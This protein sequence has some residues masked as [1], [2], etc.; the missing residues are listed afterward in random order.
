[1]GAACTPEYLIELSEV[2]IGYEGRMVHKALNLQL[3]AGQIVGLIGPSGCGKTTLMRTLL[4]LNRPVG[5]A[6]KIL[7]VDIHHVDVKTVRAVQDQWGVMFQNSAL[8]SA[9]TVAENILFPLKERY[10]LSTALQDQI[11]D[12]KMQMVGLD[13]TVKSYY[14]SAL[15]G[16]MKK[17]V[18]LARAL[19]MDPKI[20]FLDEPTA[21]LDPKSADAFDDLLL[22][23]HQALGVS[24]LMITHDL[25]SLWRITDRVIFL[26]EGT[27]LANAPMHELVKHRHPIIQR[28][29]S[30]YRA[31][32]RGVA[33]KGVG[34][35]H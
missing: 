14:P 31:S 4:M 30:G 7:G 9:M 28:Y 12:L 29:F 10:T 32:Q 23:L 20:L 18:A 33:T 5:G 34:R 17:R 19:V 24:L 8:F 13:L 3:D 27:V 26:A 35:E 11:V 15:S 16:G 25:D 22:Q 21:G 2:A 1:M 6:I